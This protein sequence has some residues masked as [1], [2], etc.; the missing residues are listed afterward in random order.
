MP[1]FSKETRQGIW[2]RWF[3]R[4]KPFAKGAQALVY[5]QGRKCPKSCLLVNSG[6]VVKVYQYVSKAAVKKTY[7]S[8]KIAHELFPENTPFAKAFR[9][10]DTV[11]EIHVEEIPISK[12]F[13]KYLAAKR[14]TYGPMGIEQKRSPKNTRAFNRA[15]HTL[16]E[17]YRQH[18]QRLNQLE[19][20][21]AKAGIDA[22]NEH[23]ANV[24]L[25]HSQPP[26]FFEPTV[27]S[28]AK[29]RDFVSRQNYSP[30]K[31]RRIKYYLEQIDA[32]AK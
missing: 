1:K 32:L 28:T 15:V 11:H 23:L 3:R 19:T 6:N 17:T 22:D 29:V 24:S 27:Y 10:N 26:I 21:M 31:L 18:A 14:K 9:S 12:D 20:E 25:V 7:Y 4:T 5:K 13:E 16:S 30:A 8:L 2:N